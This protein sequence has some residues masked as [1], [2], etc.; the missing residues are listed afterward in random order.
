M[1][2][3]KEVDELLTKLA[4]ICTDTDPGI[5]GISIIRAIDHD[6]D[7]GTLFECC[8]TGRMDMKENLELLHDL[9]CMR[10][11]VM[12]KMDGGSIPVQVLPVIP[13]NDQN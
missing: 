4:Q 6:P 8:V 13:K 11:N 9:V 12:D 10:L 3:D 1:M 5:V 7:K 2:N